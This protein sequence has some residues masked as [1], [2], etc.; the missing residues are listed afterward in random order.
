MPAS[1]EQLQK[2]MQAMVEKIN[3]L[4]IER[5]ANNL[6]GNLIEMRKGLKQ[7]NT[8]TLPSV[9]STLQELS[10]ILQSANSTLAEDSPQRGQLTQTLDEVGRMSRSLREL[11]DYLNRH[12]ESLLRGRPNDATAT[13]LQP[14]SSR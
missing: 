13:N 5:I 7:F 12:P 1:F 10:K 4:P 14:S 11:S 6:D 9:Q 2:Q 8:Q 3:K